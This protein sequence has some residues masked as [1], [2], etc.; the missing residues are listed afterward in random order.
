MHHVMFLLF[1][2]ICA[3]CCVNLSAQIT[4]LDVDAKAGC[5]FAGE[6]AASGAI[7]GF[8]SS[9]EAQE[10]VENVLRQVGLSSNFTIKA[11]NVS[12]AQ[13]YVSKGDRYILYSEQ[14][15]ADIYHRTGD[16]WSQIAILA[17][18]IGHHLNG[19]TLQ[20]DGSRPVL[21]LEADKF[22][23]FVLYKL[24]ANLRQAQAAVTTLAD[25]QGSATHP[26]K[27][28]RLEA[29]AVGFREA[30]ELDDQPETD[31]MEESAPPPERE[32]GAE[33]GSSSTWTE[34]V[35]RIADRE[36]KVVRYKDL[37]WMNENLN[38]RTEGSW[39]AEK[40]QRNCERYGRLYSWRAAR[41][42]CAGLGA[43][44]RLPS[45]EDWR[46]LTGFIIDNPAADG[47][48][49]QY[50][51]YGD[52]PG[53]ARELN[54]SVHFWTSTAKAADY[55]AVFSFFNGDQAMPSTGQAFH[56]K[57]RYVRCVKGE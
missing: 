55:Y 34:D 33:A 16:F 27:A 46:R 13:A 51:G 19:H 42:A 20:T 53:Q 14:F 8:D 30:R 3:F 11:A 48:N 32:A 17:H 25:E 37:T 9:R 26:P 6:P 2:C 31:S 45:L 4:V 36:V 5:S 24:G 47:I 44:W 10:V 15:M 54:E 39:C 57:G 41:D 52:L 35:I 49:M 56:P 22:S 21:E 23:G 40:E 12:N 28:A 50:G 29:I 18:E 43:G 7:Y 38:V 1:F